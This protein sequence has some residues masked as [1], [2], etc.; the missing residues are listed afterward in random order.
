MARIVLVALVGVWLFNLA[1]LIAG[2][3]PGHT[4][5]PNDAYAAPPA[6][7]QTEFGVTP[8]VL[9]DGVALAIRSASV[10]PGTESTISVA[11]TLAEPAIVDLDVYDSSGR[12]I[13][14]QTSRRLPAGRSHVQIQSIERLNAGHYWVRARVGDQVATTSVAVHG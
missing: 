11:L 12:C 4:V 10:I 8:R 9:P 7:V 13:L 2:G 5:Q 1:R 6:A 3:L 14:T